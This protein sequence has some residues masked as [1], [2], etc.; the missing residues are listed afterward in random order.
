MRILGVDFGSKRIG[1]AVSDELFITAQGV[2]TLVRRSLEQDLREIKDFIKEHGV[3]EVVVGLPL[4][5]NGTHSQKTKEAMEFMESLS[6]AVDVPV[7]TWDERLSTVQAERT[8]LEA[9]LSRAKRKR[10]MDK[11]AAQVIL[12][13]YLDSRKKG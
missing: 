12:Q 5:M 8:L 2:K 11:M 1:I 9:D 7:K 13:G 10:V 4:N 3:I 6:K